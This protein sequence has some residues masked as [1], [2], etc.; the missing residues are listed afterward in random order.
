MKKGSSH[1]LSDYLELWGFE[2][3]CL[4]F[5][6]GSL[7]FGLAVTPID[8][9]CSSDDT[10]NSIA[11]KSIQFLNGL[12][13]GLDIQ[14]VQD[15]TGGNESVILAHEEL[16]KN[17]TNEAV[18]S[19]AKA[20]AERFREYDRQALIPKHSL[21]VFVRRPLTAA[22]VD[23]PKLFTKQKQYPEIAEA[24]LLRE[25]TALEQLR[26]SVTQGLSGIGLEVKGL[27]GEEIV[28]LTYFQWNPTRPVALGKYDPEDIRAS[29]LLTDVAIYEKGFALS[30]MHHRVLSLKIL[31][32]QTFSSM[33]SQLRDLPF[34]SRLFLSIHVPNQTKELESLQTSRRIAF[35][36]VRGKKGVSDIESEAKLQDLETLLEQMI[37]QG[38]KVFHVSLNVL[39]R[40]KSADDLE[41]KIAQTLMVFRNLNGAE[42]MEESLA[43]FG[44]F[45][46][47]AIPNARSKERMKRVKS[48]NLADLLPIFGPWKGFQKPSVLLRSRQGS[49][50]SFDPFDSGLANSN[51][52]ISGGSG[53]GKSFL[54]NILLLQ[55]LKENPKVYFV[56]IGG[57]YKK[58][59]E[60]LSGQY[61]PLGVNSGLSL[62]PFDLGPGETAVSSQK[63]KFLVGLIELMTK[64]ED[65]ARLPKLERAEIEEAIQRVYE[66][67]TNPTLSNLREILLEHPDTEIRRYGRI[68]TPWCGDTPFG[69]FVDRPTNI[70]LNN[71]IVAFDLKGMESYPDL[72]AVC[73]F[74]ITD[75][76]WREV[77]KDRH[78]MK[79]LVFDEC[80]KLLKNESGMG[81]IE[82]VFRTFRKY[83][84]SAIAISQ[85]IDDFA[86]SKIAGAI[87]PNCSI[88]WLLMQQ[89]SDSSRIQEVLGLNENE[90]A[91]VKSLYQEKGRFSEAFLL[92]QK[93]R[94]VA[95]IESIPLEYW[96][97][98]TDPKDLAAVDK[99]ARDQPEIK[100]IERLASLA[101]KY[102]RGVAAYEKEGG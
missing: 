83:F 91:L 10:T 80:W 40:S 50:V 22:L 23:K 15:I 11:Q 56:D 90:L 49:L 54:T 43:S 17:A 25:L 9:S 68:L 99:M 78:Q 21:Y 13:P 64:E 16:G 102:P 57:S 27:T 4:L 96:I 87:L 70:E 14:F 38:E 46:E 59:C 100:H 41:E 30:D 94:T 28:N 66:S 63:I 48:S 3:E 44:I 101:E 95:L 18:V 81:F 53:S 84:A 19:L 65:V 26:D 31:P 39:L 58:L 67:S 89:Q 34:D 74:I 37:A 47:F 1:A 5:S 77:Q 82:E 92:A 52:L 42:A 69:K 79:F 45:S 32:D 88:K 55:M 35:S 86:K 20:R 6:D 75:F 8:V 93:D 72:Q 98:T 97:A 36:M 62:N 60:N 29:L 24:R 76:V 73:L 2:E 33:A 12:P 51:Q 7:G 61:L 71:S 85:D